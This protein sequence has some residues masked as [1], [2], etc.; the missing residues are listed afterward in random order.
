MQW[1]G[2]QLD[3]QSGIIPR[4][5]KDVFNVMDESPTTIEFTTHVSYVKSY[6]KQICDL[7]P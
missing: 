3:I 1:K 2:T 7:V 4:I 5:V 6:L